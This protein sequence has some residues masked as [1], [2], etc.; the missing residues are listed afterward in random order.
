M[1][2]SDFD[3]ELA[4]A[5][6]FVPDVGSTS[7]STSTSAPASAAPADADV[8]PVSSDFEFPEIPPAL[9]ESAPEYEFVSICAGPEVALGPDVC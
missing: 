9:L 5:H 8:G 1:L 2:Y 4:A 6:N 3:A 7:T